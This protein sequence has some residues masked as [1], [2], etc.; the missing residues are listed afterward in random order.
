M[1]PHPPGL[2][3]THPGS[4]GGSSLVVPALGFPAETLMLERVGRRAYLVERSE[5][6]G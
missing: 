5:P 3:R 6:S 4:A 2:P 1:V